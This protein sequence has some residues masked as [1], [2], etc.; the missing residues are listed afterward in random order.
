MRIAFISRHEFNPI[1]GG[2]ERVT[3]TLIKEFLINGHDVYSIVL[4]KENSGYSS[5]CD[6]YY[7]PEISIY[8]KVNREWYNNLL[9]EKGINVIINQY[10]L[11]RESYLFL[12]IDN[13]NI[14]KLT[15]IHSKALLSY[16]T[17]A[18]LVMCSTWEWKKIVKLAFL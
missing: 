9:N 6:C 8:S 7:F 2:I 14:K 4:I 15:C 1:K 5:P 12:D 3:D 10:G 18:H 11:S 13:H 16:D 17:Y